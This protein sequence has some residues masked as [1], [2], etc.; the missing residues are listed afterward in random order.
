VDCRFV[1]ISDDPQGILL[2]FNCLHEV[3]FGDLWSAPN[4]SGAQSIES[5]RPASF[6]AFFA[7]RTENKV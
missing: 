7:K 6:L 2:R 4:N 1:D 5:V 3:D